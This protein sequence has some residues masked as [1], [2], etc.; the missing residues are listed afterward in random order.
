MSSNFTNWFYKLIG[1][2]EPQEQY[3]INFAQKEVTPE[4][5]CYKIDID[6]IM[7]TKAHTG[8]FE[9]AAY[10]L[11][12][13][14]NILIQPNE[15][16]MI[17][18]KLAFIIPDGYWLKLRERSGLANKGIHVLGGVID[19][20]YTGSVRVILYNSDKEPLIIQKGKAIAQ[21]TVEKLTKSAVKELNFLTFDR[22]MKI[23][24]R[25]EKGFGSSDVKTN[26]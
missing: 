14:D 4:I 8:V 1:P 2:N 10:D 16:L 17:D 6:A 21:F 24:K 7:P 23:R 25:G 22:E 20:G 13:I 3:R 26:R 5:G 9:D 11:Y 15:R 18:T 19:S 12:A